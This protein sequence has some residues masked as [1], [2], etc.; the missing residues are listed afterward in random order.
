MLIQLFLLLKIFISFF[1]LFLYYLKIVN[2]PFIRKLVDIEAKK[3]KYGSNKINFVIAYVVNGF[4]D[5]V[6]IPFVVFLLGKLV[7][8]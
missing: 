4:V 6:R 8:K 3:E 2:H 1:I 5:L 7:K